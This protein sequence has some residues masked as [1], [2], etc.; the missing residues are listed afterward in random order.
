MA[1]T[2]S[3]GR[4]GAKTL[5]KGLQILEHLAQS[6]DGLIVSEVAAAIGVHRTVATR[7]LVTLTDRGYVDR[8]ED[9]R[10]T[11]AVKILELGRAVN[12]DLRAVA[13]PAMSQ[14]AEELDATAVLTV[15]D[16][17]EAV[18]IASSRRSRRA[19]R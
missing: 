16:G 18:V 15:Q 14:L 9:R 6:R 19:G 5:D 10:Y 3:E 13:T 1:V 7:L 17:T 12:A 2:D 11:V 8:R 4:R